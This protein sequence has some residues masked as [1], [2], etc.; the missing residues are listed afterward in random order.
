MRV[1]SSYQRHLETVLIQYHHATPTQTTQS[2]NYKD[3]LKGHET[4]VFLR[5]E[6]PPWKKK[7]SSV[8]ALESWFALEPACSSEQILYVCLAGWLVLNLSPTTIVGLQQQKARVVLS[9]GEQDIR[10][11]P[12]TFACF[13]R[14]ASKTWAKKHRIESDIVCFKEHRWFYGIVLCFYS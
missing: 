8:L 3:G 9:F 4:Q 5:A 10:V 14:D 13:I 11:V 7:E 6:N 1:G 2:R 12:D